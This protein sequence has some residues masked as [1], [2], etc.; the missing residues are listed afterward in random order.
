MKMTPSAMES[1]K[2]AKICP[3]WKLRHEYSKNSQNAMR[4]RDYS[5]RFCAQ[6]EKLCQ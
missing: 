3:T 2:L 4:N 6:P 5:T 1:L